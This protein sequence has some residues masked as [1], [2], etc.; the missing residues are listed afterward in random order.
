MGGISSEIIAQKDLMLIPN[1]PRFVRENDELIVTSKVSN[2]LNEATSGI[3]KLLLFD[4]G[5]GNPIEA[6]VESKEIQN[7]NCKAK[8]STTVQWKIKIPKDIQGLQYKI[9]A[10]AGNFTDGEE[11]ILPV[12]KNAILITES[13]PVW[14]KAKDTKIITFDALTNT[15]NTKEN[16]KISINLV[17]NPIWSAIESLPY[18]MEYEHDCAEQ[19]FSKLFANSISEKS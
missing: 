11:N 17:T 3:A 4:A 13:Q 9:V 6:L 15:S 18:L 12:L 2:L 1:M 7:F 8:G 10:K 14:L 19:T 16:H 5:T